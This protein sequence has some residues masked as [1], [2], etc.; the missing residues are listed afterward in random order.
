MPKV[1]TDYSNTIFYKI[2]CNDSM[3]NSLYIGHTTNFV[4]RKQAHKQGC[5]NNKNPGYN[6][7][8]YDT[9]RNCGGWNNWT[10]DIIGFKKCS[11]SYEA[12]KREQEYYD[13]YNADLNSIPP[14]P[15]VKIST[16]NNVPY[17]H[18]GTCNVSLH[19]K[20]RYDIHINSKK[21][22][23]NINLNK[24]TTI[25]P[26]TA[27]NA[28]TRPNFH[29]N[30]C[31]YT[32]SKHSQYE[33]HLMTGK[34]KRL[35]NPNEN[36]P[37]GTIH[38]CHCG[39]I[40]KHLSSLCKHRK[41]CDDNQYKEEHVQNQP[42][43]TRL[44]VEL[45]KQNQEFKDLIIEGRR[46]FQ[47]IITDQNKQM[48]EMAGKAGNN[49]NCHNKFNPNL[50]LNETCKDKIMRNVMKETTIDKQISLE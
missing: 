20:Q 10:M 18:C 41:D 4:Q 6:L 39:K 47:Q 28:Q 35:T 23:N 14:L 30:I 48:M 16:T 29:C 1:K 38:T 13:E 34:H 25:K 26:H 46:E 15:P 11:D 33:R 22:N 32:T 24:M 42:D 31:D 19:G 17:F 45:L 5:N 21:H 8:L 3:C 9:I 36:G 7:K 37:K 43:N 27:G 50:F 12:R 49:T 40:Y 2:V 44:I